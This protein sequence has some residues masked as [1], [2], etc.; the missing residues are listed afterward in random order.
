MSLAQL[1]SGLLALSVVAG[2]PGIALAGTWIVGPG[3]GADFPD[4]PSGIAGS[5]AGDTL[6]VRSAAYSGGFTLHEGR[7]IVGYG[8][9]SVSGPIVVSAIPAG[10]RAVVVNVDALGGIAL[11]ACQGTVILQEMI[12]QGYSSIDGCVDVR[13]RQVSMSAPWEFNVESTLA[14]TNSRVE[15]VDSHLQGPRN[16]VGNGFDGIEA[17]R[18][19]SAS[20][21]HFVN[22]SAIGGDGDDQS[23]PKYPGGA[24]APGIHLVSAGAEF[25]LAGS[26]AQGGNGGDS[27]DAPDCCSNG[28]GASGIQNDGVTW[29]SNTTFTGGEGWPSCNCTE[30][31]APAMAGNGSY[32]SFPIADPTLGATGVPTGGGTV[33][34]ALR[35][36][37]GANAVL[38]IGR[39]PV[40]VTDPD[41]QIEELVEP[42]QTY[43]LGVIP[44]SGEVDFALGID[45]LVARRRFV[46]ALPGMLLVAQ[47]ET[48][49]DN[50]RDRRTN[51]IPLVVR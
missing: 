33:T 41:I 2:L 37:P 48:S 40:L 45:A 4:I 16:F 26:S 28:D 14:V 9:A 17:L 43:D 25:I 44:A 31:P 10:Q 23:L 36:P 19:G 39:R 7:T 1:R 51:S 50:A 38:R 6:L 5:H 47:G 18:C 12:S 24:G 3:P 35:G 27:F 8:S 21:V 13:L 46:N 20:R 30:S 29:Y 49:I 11:S 15:I 34:L 22:S 32:Q 42:L